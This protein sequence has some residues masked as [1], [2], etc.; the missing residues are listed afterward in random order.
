MNISKYAFTFYI[1]MKFNIFLFKLFIIL[2][3]G[4][5]FKKSIPK[6]KCRKENLVISRRRNSELLG[7]SSIWLILLIC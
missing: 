1:N 3:N 4:S 5:F 2:T 7:E 6:Y